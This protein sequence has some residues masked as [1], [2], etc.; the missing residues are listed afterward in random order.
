MSFPLALT[1][2]FI[3]ILHNICS[4]HQYNNAGPACL[5]VRQPEKFPFCR[6]A[7]AF[8]VDKKHELLHIKTIKNKDLHCYMDRVKKSGSRLQEERECM[9]DIRADLEKNRIYVTIGKIED[10]AEMA[11]IREKIKSE[12]VKLKKGFTCLTDLRDYE[13][14]DEIFEEYLKQAQQALLEAG[15]STVVRVHRQV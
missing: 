12:C 14:Q 11:R 7:G 2:I 6:G 9:H 4:F 10:E 1:A 13:Y 3:T 15:M 5:Q 8:S